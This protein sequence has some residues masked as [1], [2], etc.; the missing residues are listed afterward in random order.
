MRV[1]A[2]RWPSRGFVAVCAA[3]LLVAAFFAWGFSTPDLDRVWTLH[4]ELKI[5]R[6]SKLR[7]AD[8]VLL[9]ECMARHPRLAR[10]LLNGD[11][12]GIISAHGDGWLATPTATVLRT[13]QAQ[14]YR[15]LALEV[16]TPRDLLPFRI[17]V[18]GNGWEKQQE[19]D[20]QGQFEIDLPPVPET[21]EVIEVRMRGRAFEP[22][23]SILG[24]RV[25][26]GEKP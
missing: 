10:E 8:R 23:P 24:V 3:Y 11:E 9:E 13:A 25:R 1:S 12:I 20:Q 16:Q 18:K 6:L 15:S 5:G 19:V 2:G 26:F 4:H 14:E 17:V 7:A 22:D 21:P